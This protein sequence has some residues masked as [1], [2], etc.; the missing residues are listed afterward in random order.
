V[1]FLEAAK[2][3]LTHPVDGLWTR[4]IAGGAGIWERLAAAMEE[5]E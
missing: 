1:R 4:Q 5:H 3:L 2:E